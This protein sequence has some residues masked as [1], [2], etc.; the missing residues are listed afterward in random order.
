M[1]IY[2][3][4]FSKAGQVYPQFT[5]AYYLGNKRIRQRFADLEKAR[6]EAQ[7]AAIKLANAEHEALKLSGTDRAI[8]VECLAAARA[9][10]K[11]LSLLV[12]EYTEAVALLPAGAT[13]KEAVR[14]FSRRSSEVREVRTVL[15]LKEEFVA[16]KEKAGMS[17]RHLKDIRYRLGRLAERFACP[18]SE[19]TA[20]MIEKHLDDLGLKGRNRVNEITSI[21]SALRHAV[22]QKLAP[23]DL[24]EELAAI[25]RPKVEPP[26]T[27]IWTPEELRELLE[28]APDSMV[29]LIVLGGLCG[30]RTSEI[31]RADWSHITPEGNHLA[32]ITRKGRT[33]SRRLVPLCD[34]AKAWLAPLMR[35]EGAICAIDREDIIVRKIASA[36]NASRDSRGVQERFA[37]R[38]NALRHSY[39]TYRVAL[40]ADIH[41]TSLEMGNSPAMIT[42]HYLQLATKE[43]AAAWF[44]V[45]P[46]APSNVIEMPRPQPLVASAE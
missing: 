9:A 13:L 36:L 33:P 43:Q 45:T 14:E 46:T 44:K 21:S 6:S 42:K 23:K 22:R 30:M 15:Q 29:P 25:Q 26:A 8:Y 1:K 27:L 24:L 32:V 35:A 10:G 38:E 7:A 12:A 34:A 2:T 3:T 39:G 41:R 11:P 19:L 40:T 31:I 5:V 37:W 17:A 28:S 20:A 18:V 4:P 16:A